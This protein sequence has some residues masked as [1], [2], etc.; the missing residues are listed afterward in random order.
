[1]DGRLVPHRPAAARETRRKKNT[2]GGQA[3]AAVEG[4]L[5]TG[6]FVRNMSLSAP[7]GYPAHPAA[8]AD[9]GYLQTAG[10]LCNMS[11]SAPPGAIFRVLFN[12]TQNSLYKVDGDGI[13]ISL[14]INEITAKRA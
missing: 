14:I 11:V 9:K 5:A 3:G 6:G 4:R 13:V 2:P 12:I 1:M 10:F 7:T 8:Q